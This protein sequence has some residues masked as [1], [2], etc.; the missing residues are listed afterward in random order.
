MKRTAPL[1]ILFVGLLTVAL[2]SPHTL[3]NAQHLLADIGIGA[4]VPATPI[5]TRVQELDARQK[6]LDAQQAALDASTNN[7]SLWVAL[8]VVAGLVAVNFILDWRR[9]RA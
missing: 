3:Q 5:N 8:T 9:N 2:V 1:L 7:T 4:T 6:A